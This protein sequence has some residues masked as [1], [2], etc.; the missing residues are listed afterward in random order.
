ME[1]VTDVVF[2]HVVE[3]SRTVYI[4]ANSPMPLGGPMPVV[5]RQ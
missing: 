3:K 1:A 5:K 4:L 2:R